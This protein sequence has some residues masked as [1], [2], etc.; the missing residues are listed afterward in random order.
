LPCAGRARIPSF[1]RRSWILLFVLVGCSGARGN[2]SVTPPKPLLPATVAR[3]DFTWS[4]GEQTHPIRAG[5]ARILPGGAVEIVLADTDVDP[6]CALLEPGR[7]AVPRERIRLRVPRGLDVE[8]PLGR[9]ISPAPIAIDSATVEPF[10]GDIARYSLVLDDVQ[11]RSGGRVLGKL[12]WLDPPRLRGDKKLLGSFG[13][14][15]FDVPLC[16]TQPDLDVVASLPGVHAVAPRGGIRG[17][18]VDGAFLGA[19]AFAILQTTPGASPRIDHLELWTEPLVGCLDR[20]NAKGTA[21]VLGVDPETGLGQRNGTRQPIVRADCQR[22]RSRWDCLGE[23]ELL[24]GFLELRAVDPRVGGEV[25]GVLALE[26]SGDTNVAGE[27]VAE[28]CSD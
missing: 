8:Y 11:L 20:A 5:A 1:V 15:R 23:P 9:P 27:I 19:R 3:G 17:R 7:A 2:G 12:A 16:A 25:R 4:I 18:T 14:G 28:V 13:E 6:P 26:G 10:D 24:R 22:A 21:V